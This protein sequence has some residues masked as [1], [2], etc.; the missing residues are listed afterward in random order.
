VFLVCFWCVIVE[1]G[2]TTAICCLL[3]IIGGLYTDLGVIDVR[4]D[5]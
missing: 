5:E 1:V 3:L 2:H 4:V